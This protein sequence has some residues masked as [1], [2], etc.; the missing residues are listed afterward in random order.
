MTHTSGSNQTL[1]SSAEGYIRFGHGR[2]LTTFGQL[3][4]KGFGVY[5]SNSSLFGVVHD[6][7]SLTVGTTQLYSLSSYPYPVNLIEII[8]NVGTVYFY[9]NGVLADTL[10]GG[11]TGFGGQEATG[12]SISLK[13]NENRAASLTIVQGRFRFRYLPSPF[14]TRN[15]T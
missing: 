6:G 9:V 10:S 1:L 13:N 2:T 4:V 12:F 11:P 14:Y 8:S 15:N 3:A 7:T 5:I